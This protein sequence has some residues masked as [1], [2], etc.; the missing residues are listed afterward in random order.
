[1]IIMVIVIIRGG[2]GVMV[3]IVGG[4]GGMMMMMTR[5]VIMVMGMG[6]G[7]GAGMTGTAM[8]EVTGEMIIIK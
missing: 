2:V 8:R 7:R 4:V 6:G 3:G 1:M 5:M